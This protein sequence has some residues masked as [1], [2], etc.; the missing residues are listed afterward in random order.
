MGLIYSRTFVDHLDVSWQRY[1]GTQNKE[2][3]VERCDEL[4][5]R[6]V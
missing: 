3:V 4:G 5:I 2:E 1:F 6:T